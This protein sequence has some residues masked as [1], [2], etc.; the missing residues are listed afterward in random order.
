MVKSIDQVL[1]KTL[2]NLNLSN[3]I[4][5][6]KALNIWPEIIGEK[7]KNY[8][9][10]SYINKGILFVTVKSS[11]W[12]HQ[13]LFLKKELILKLNS[14][15]KDQV[16]KDI[17]FK[18]G[19]VNQNKDFISDSEENFNFNEIELTEE[20]LKKIKGNLNNTFDSEL[21]EKLYSI[22]IK[23]KKLEKWKKKEGWVRCNYCSALHPTDVSGCMVCELK[24]N[25]NLNKLENLL[26]E[27][28]WLKYEEIIEIYPELLNSNYNIIKQRLLQKFWKDIEDKISLVVKEENQEVIQKFK[29][30]VQYYVMLKKSI[31]PEELSRD[32]IK[33]IIGENYI[34]IYD[35]L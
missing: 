10:A 22:M 21:N 33:E 28:P 2:N 35:R 34:K 9:K 15:L 27:T 23:D 17:R 11:T 31:Y 4:T 30:L 26:L 1:E 29:V 16:I 19:S 24:N 32:I 18:I 5:E 12:A 8:T 20:E 25:K 13:L 14:K 7:L 6:R 3:K